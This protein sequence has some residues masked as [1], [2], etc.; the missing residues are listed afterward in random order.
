VPS[1]GWGFKDPANNEAGPVIQ[2]L[3]LPVAGY[4]W[5][6]DYPFAAIAPG[7]SLVCYS[8]SNAY[9]SFGAAYTFEVVPGGL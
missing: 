6:Y 4:N 9:N 5:L 2:S 3:S 1:T 7:D 8:D